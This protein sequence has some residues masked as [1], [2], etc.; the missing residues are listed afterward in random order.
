LPAPL[1]H[2]AQPEEI[3]PAFVFLA[4]P[5]TRSVCHPCCPL[6]GTSVRPL[7]G[8]KPSPCVLEAVSHH[9]PGDGFL[10]FSVAHVTT[11]CGNLCSAASLHHDQVVNP[12]LTGWADHRSRP[13][14][15]AYCVGWKRS[16][17]RCAKIG[18]G[19][20]A[21]PGA[22]HE[23]LETHVRHLHRRNRGSYRACDWRIGIVTAS[24][25]HRRCGIFTCTSHISRD[26]W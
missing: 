8:Q 14:G 6:G 13:L 17:H 12:R 10:S 25:H 20:F 22:S 5:F 23:T 18:G 9:A 16:R 2:R 26:I 11:P 3:A 21:A 15:H 4:A 1:R 7:T 24:S 19:F